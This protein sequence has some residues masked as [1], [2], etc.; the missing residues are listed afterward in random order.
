MDKEELEKIV[1]NNFEEMSLQK[2]T[3]IQGMGEYQ[4]DSTPAASAIS[5]ATIQVSRASSGKCLSWGSGAAFSAYF[6]H[7]RWC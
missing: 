6:T 2:M 3:E 5:R 1:G 4:V 7:K